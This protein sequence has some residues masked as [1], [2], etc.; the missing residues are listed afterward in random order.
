MNRRLLACAAVAVMAGPGVARAAPSCA[1]ILAM[2]PQPGREKAGQGGNAFRPL[3]TVAPQPGDHDRLSIGID[4]VRFGPPTTAA[5][6]PPGREVWIGNYRVQDVPAFAITPQDE[7]VA[8]I[9]DNGAENGKPIPLPSG[10]LADPRL[11][12][13][14]T[15]W[16]L[17]QGQTIRASLGSKLDYSGSAAVEPP[18]NGGAP[19]RSTNMHT[20]G[21]LVSPYRPKKPGQGE[22]GDYVLDVTLAP[23]SA[24]SAATDDCQADL[25]PHVHGV[26]NNRLEHE[27]RIP[28]TPGVNSIAD[29]QHPSG[30]FWYH[31]HPHG[32]SR[33]QVNGGTTGVIT[34]GRLSDYACTEGGPD[35]ALQT[36]A[37][38]VF[39][40]LV[41]P[42]IG[43]KMASLMRQAGLADIAV[44]FEA[45]RLFTVVGQVDPE[46]RRNWVDQFAAAR[47]YM[48]RV[49]GGEPQA[50]AFTE[51][52][53]AY[54]DRPDTASYTALYLASGIVPKGT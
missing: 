46:R 5:V 23:G 24:P 31:P 37:D 9:S 20:H 4:A 51:A 50:D 13:G 7:T 30:L 53:L 18:H 43:R 33:G 11:I 39:P 45:D 34:V 15:H 48:A 42:F 19:C 12:Y 26:T 8:T 28:G 36:S 52:F 27:I 54:Q 41:D 22:Y 14:G 2:F 40:A 25:G 32:Y 21:L 10:C 47:P 3:P 1:D 16:S 44:H 49:L 29:G 17:V 38:R 35:P 6:T